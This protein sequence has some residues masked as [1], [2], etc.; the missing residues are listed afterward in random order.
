MNDPIQVNGHDP[1]IPEEALRELNHVHVPLT[2]YIGDER[3][4]IGE[5][6][7]TGNQ[8]E[9]YIDQGSHPESTGLLC[10]MIQDGII[11]DVSVTFNA[12]P[13]TPVCRDG[14]IRWVR[15]Y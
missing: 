3:R 13:A 5:A 2:V 9:A 4:I 12:P 10:R 6:V 8:I 15:N 11:Q 14:S 7:V 1:A